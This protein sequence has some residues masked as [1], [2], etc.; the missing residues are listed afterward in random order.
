MEKF[1]PKELE[2]DLI[3]GKA[4][5]SV[6][7]CTMEK[8][9]PKNLPAFPPI[10]D[11]DE[12]NIRT[13]VKSKYKTGVYVLSIE[14]GESLSCKIAKGISNLPYRFSKSNELQINSNPLTQNLMII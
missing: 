4:W 13:Y 2:I 6:G 10:S 8:I 3:D 14:G 9:R 11:F 12:I 5:I 7:A 1:V